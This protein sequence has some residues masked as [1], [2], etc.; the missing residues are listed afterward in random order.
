MD[1][2]TVFCIYKPGFFWPRLYLKCCNRNQLLWSFHLLCIFQFVFFWHMYLQFALW[3]I[4]SF[5]S[6]SK[7]NCTGLVC[8]V[9]CYV[10]STEKDAATRMT[11]HGSVLSTYVYCRLYA[12]CVQDHL[13]L[14]VLLLWLR[15]SVDSLGKQI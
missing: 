13:A 4:G 10:L 7:T 9:W 12:S 15:S 6:C 2:E 5:T 3:L 14:G 1:L 8:L 11:I